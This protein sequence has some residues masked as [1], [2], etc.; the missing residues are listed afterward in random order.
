MKINR[1]HVIGATVGMVALTASAPMA[2]ASPPTGLTPTTLATA[3]LQ[4]PVHVNHD[5]VRFKT[6][7]ATDVRVQQIVFAP[8][9]NSGWHHHPGMVMVVVATGSVTLWDEHCR[10]TTYGPG[11]PHGAA[12]VESGDEPGLVTSKDGATNYVTYVVPKVA[13]AVFRIEDTAPR[14]AS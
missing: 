5:G 11:L 10:Q 9:S 7:E 6:K 1:I 14:C 3:S 13:P 8:G 4:R 12:F 2:Y